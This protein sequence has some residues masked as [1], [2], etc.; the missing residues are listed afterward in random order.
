MHIKPSLHPPRQNQNYIEAKENQN[1]QKGKTKEKAKKEKKKEHK[2]DIASKTIHH[3]AHIALLC[4]AMLSMHATHGGSTHILFCSRIWQDNCYEWHPRDA[5]QHNTIMVLPH[6]RSQ[7][8]V[9]GFP[10]FPP[11]VCGVPRF[12]PEV[13]GIP[14][15]VVLWSDSTL[16][17]EQRPGRLNLNETYTIGLRLENPSHTPSLT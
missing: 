4:Y 17:V 6:L 2:A 7:T 15:L 1:K 12:P 13:G 11:E 9:C 14:R 16:G 5:T 8:Q 10:R 3:E